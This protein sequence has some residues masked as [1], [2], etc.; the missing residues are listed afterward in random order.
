MAWLDKTGDGRVYLSTYP[1]MLGLIDELRGDGT[2]RFG[3]GHFDLIVID[4]AHRSVYQK[5]RHIF[6]YFDSPLVGLT[7]TSRDEIDW[8]TYTL[9]DLESQVPTHEYGLQ[10]AVDD[11]FLV[12]MKAVSVPAGFPLTGIH[13]DDLST[14]E[15]EQWDGTDW[16]DDD[17]GSTG[18]VEADEWWN[19]VT[20]AMLE[21]A[22]RRL[23]G[24]VQFIEKKR[25]A[26]VYVNFADAL[27]DETTFDLIDLDTG[28]TFERYRKK[29]QVFLVEHLSRPVLRKAYNNWPLT[30]VD[31][32]ELRNIL[33]EV[34]P[35]TEGTRQ[36]IEQE[37]GGFGLFVRSLVGLDRGAAMTALSAFLNEGAYGANQIEF[38]KLIVAE[39][40]DKGVVSAARFYEDPYTS[41]SPRGPE[42]LFTRDQI[43]DLL[44]VLD[45]VRRNAGAA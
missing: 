2:R 45:Q 34:S 4:E 44:A 37:S 6:E 40:A 11:G 29:V 36:R 43:T 19:D 16:G 22:R 18:E 13:Y 14:D 17:A 30:D 5:Y 42:D 25:Q 31:I 12:P 38:V 20:V 27:G 21:N 41:L 10:Q 33:D 26:A 1:T 39:L 3:P 15:Q 35:A 8:N 24:L 23:R 7:A 28:Q 32:D 9:F